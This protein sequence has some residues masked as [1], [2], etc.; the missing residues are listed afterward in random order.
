MGSRRTPVII[1]MLLIAG[2]L[3]FLLPRIPS[4]MKIAI[5]ICLALMGFLI[6]GPQ[7]LIVM[8]LAMDYGGKER[9]ASAA[10]FIDSMNYIGAAAGAFVAGY[11]VDIW[12]WHLAFHFWA[13]AIFM[14]ILIMLPMWRS[15]K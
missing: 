12:N 9:A 13:T 3:T 10:G 8:T 5:V 1:V 11:L 4:E 6:D 15:E 2:F 7:A 14:T